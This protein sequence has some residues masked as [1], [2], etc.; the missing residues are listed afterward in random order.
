MP[1]RQGKSLARVGEGVLFSAVACFVAAAL[2]CGLAVHAL[3]GAPD[4]DGEPVSLRIQSD[5]GER[6]AGRSSSDETSDTA[7]SE[8][9][10]REEGERGVWGQLGAGVALMDDE[11][12]R[13]ARTEAARAEA[14]RVSS[15][16]EQ[17]APFSTAGSVLACVAG[18]GVLSAVVVRVESRKRK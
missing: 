9:A 15:R 12:V 17:A 3:A 6:M 5:S 7:P 11:A 16:Q 8:D 10:L 4:P 18:A 2:S 1:V 13:E 14:R